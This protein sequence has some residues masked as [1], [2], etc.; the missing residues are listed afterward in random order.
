MHD[1]VNTVIFEI[2]WK[3]IIIIIIGY[4]IKKIQIDMCIENRMLTWFKFLL[5]ETILLIGSAKI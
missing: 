2:Q 3:L 5:L 1:S 4:V